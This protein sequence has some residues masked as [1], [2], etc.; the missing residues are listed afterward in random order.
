MLPGQSALSTVELASKELHQLTP[1]TQDAIYR[2]PGVTPSYV[3]QIG[4]G[5]NLTQTQNSSGTQLASV[6]ATNSNL[7]AVS[8]LISGSNVHYNPLTDTDSIWWGSNVL[9]NAATIDMSASISFNKIE[10]FLHPLLPTCTSFSIQTSPDNSTW[11]TIFQ[12]DGLPTLVVAS[13]NAT[14]TAR[15]FRIVP[16]NVGSDGYFR[17]VA[18]NV[19]NMIDES[20]N[21]S[22]VNGQPQIT[23][24]SKADENQNS[25]PTP[26]ECDLTF[27][28]MTGRFSPFNSSSPIYGTLQNDGRGSG[29]RPNCPV[30]VTATATAYIGGP[31]YTTSNIVFNGYITNDDN[32]GGSQAIQLDESS[33]TATIICKSLLARLTTSI[34]TPVYECASLDF[35]IRD[36]CY[37][38]GIADQQINI[39]S[40]GQGVP[41]LSFSN[42]PAQ[43]IISDMITALPFLL[44]FDTYDPNSSVNFVNKGR[45]RIDLDLTRFINAS[46]TIVNF[47]NVNALKKMI[48]FGSDN[49]VYSMSMTSPPGSGLTN[50]GNVTAGINNQTTIF[51]NGTIIYM[52]DPTTGNVYSWNSVFLPAQPRHHPARGRARPH[53]RARDRSGAPPTVGAPRR[54]GAVSLPVPRPSHGARPRPGPRPLAHR[55]GRP[56]EGQLSLLYCRSWGLPRPPSTVAR[57]GGA[58]LPCRGASPGCPRALARPSSR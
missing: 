25:S 15:Y 53:H 48:I 35:I 32:P 13:F 24:D 50:I 33:K 12:G 20:A 21:V 55:A 34:D 47:V 38:C 52:I 26:S 7:G 46:S 10:V 56:S 11:T 19:F 1:Y 37:R 18:L 29:V 58:Q 41:W 16:G 17:I 4:W 40:M 27:Q 54:P 39:Q 42:S 2:T 22:W 45:S 30:I 31:A 49:A 14:L 36:I 6:S 57:A 51:V 44:A 43:S 3:V 8:N 28:N 5:G 23:I 9:P